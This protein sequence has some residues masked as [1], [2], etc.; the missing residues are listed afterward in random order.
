MLFRSTNEQYKHFSSVVEEN[1]RAVKEARDELKSL[2]LN[3]EQSEREKELAKFSSEFS[4]IDMTDSLNDAKQIV[5]DRIDQN[6]AALDVFTS[7]KVLDTERV[8]KISS[9]L[10]RYKKV[11]VQN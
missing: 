5:L 11:A 7:P 4:T 6:K 2:S 3:L 1:I 9:I 8:L 10:D